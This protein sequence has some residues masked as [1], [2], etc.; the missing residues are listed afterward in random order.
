MVKINHPDPVCRYASMKGCRSHSWLPRVARTR[1]PIA[2]TQWHYIDQDRT[3]KP[4]AN[5]TPFSAPT[6]RNIFE[7][8]IDRCFDNG[9]VKNM[10]TELLGSDYCCGS[11]L[12]YRSWRVLSRKPVIFYNNRCGM[13]EWDDREM[14][15]HD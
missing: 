6:L 10:L 5:A 13:S 7:L 14:G 9:S 1:F 2:D 12:I 11:G 8:C 15:P 3:N 4:R